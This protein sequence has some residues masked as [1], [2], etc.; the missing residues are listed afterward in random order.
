MFCFTKNELLLFTLRNFVCFFFLP[1]CQ[2]SY[3]IFQL[4]KFNFLLV[5]VCYSVVLA[6]ATL[7][8]QMHMHKHFAFELVHKTHLFACINWYNIWRGFCWAKNVY[9]LYILS[10]MRIRCDSISI[11]SVKVCTHCSAHL[12][13]CVC[14][15]FLLIAARLNGE[16]MM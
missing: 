16:L 1:R 5:C 4:Y 9:F 14:A 7:P 12:S 13:V 11:Q 3:C 8:L 10:C 2:L 15:F 6:I